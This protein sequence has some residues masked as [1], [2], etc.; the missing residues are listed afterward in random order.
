MYLLFPQG[1]KNFQEL[2]LAWYISAFSY[3]QLNK[4]DDAK[5]D[6][7]R[8][9]KINKMPDNFKNKD[10]LILIE[11]SYVPVKDIDYNSEIPVLKFRGHCGNLIING[12]KAYLLENLI[13]VASKNF[14]ERLHYLQVKSLL[15][16]AMQGAL[17]YGVAKIT[18]SQTAGIASFLLLRAF[19][20]G[21]DLRS[22]QTLAGCFYVYRFN[23]EK[24]DLDIKYM[25]K[26]DVK[27]LTIK[28][29]GSKVS[30]LR[31]F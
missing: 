16:V 15:R 14:K 1:L 2:A 11:T 13:N 9:D 23:N 17:A 27:H 29:N 25:T 7:N 20:T 24:K 22:W 18:K 10:N 19:N 5:I 6:Y 8:T 4:E 3:Q 28:V 12:E 21:P 30:M 31:I 26:S